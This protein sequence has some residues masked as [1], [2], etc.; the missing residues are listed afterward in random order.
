MYKKGDREDIRN[1]RPVSLLN[2]DYKILMK[3]LNE[4]VKISATRYNA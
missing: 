1:Y 3:V 2:T 4:P